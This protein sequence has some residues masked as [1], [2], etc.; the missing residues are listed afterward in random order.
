MAQLPPLWNRWSWISQWKPN[1]SIHT[2]THTL[3]ATEQH[4][5][6]DMRVTSWQPPGHIWKW[7]TPYI[8]TSMWSVSSLSPVISVLFRLFIGLFPL[9]RGAGRLE[10]LTRGFC[11]RLFAQSNKQKYRNGSELECHT[12]KITCQRHI[13]QNYQLLPWNV[14]SELSRHLWTAIL[15]LLCNQGWFI[16]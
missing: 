11:C 13:R 5:S 10:P 6:Q 7:Y 4:L 12:V 1:W 9:V 14:S 3:D 8:A 16:N 2:H 15:I